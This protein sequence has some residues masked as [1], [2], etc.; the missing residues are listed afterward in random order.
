M[1]LYCG[2]CG[3]SPAGRSRSLKTRLICR[4]LKGWFGFLHVQ[5]ITGIVQY[6]CVNLNSLNENNLFCSLKL[7]LRFYTVTWGRVGALIRLLHNSFCV[8]FIHWRY[9]HI[10]WVSKDLL[11]VILQLMTHNENHYLFMTWHWAA[12]VPYSVVDRM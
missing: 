4:F 1:L 12:P 10:T 11:V 7:V 5:H 3:R 2:F 6:S 9:C 8:V